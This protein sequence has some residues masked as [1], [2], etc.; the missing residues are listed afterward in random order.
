MPQT[1]PRVGLIE[2]AIVAVGIGVVAYAIGEHRATGLFAP[3]VVEDQEMKRLEV[4]YGP[5]R[6]SENGEE[7]IL[8]DIFHEE[9]GGLFVDIGANHY[10]TFSNTYYLETALGWSGLAIEPQTSFAADYLRYRPRTKFVPFFVSDVTDRDAV[11]YVP[12]NNLMASSSK[13]FAEGGQGSPTG[14]SVKT[15]TLDDILRAAGIAGIDFVSMDVELHEPAALRGFSIRT[16][17]PRIVCVEAHAEVRQE[18]L[19]YFADAGYVIIG[20]YLRADSDN[21]WFRPLSSEDA[22]RQ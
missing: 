22:L 3:Y 20:Q 16:H 4:A 18:I 6:N 17:R 7:W 2:A 13:E 1:R 9:R 8:R 19:N 11:L 12:R 14:L 15:S 21:L 10:K 5:G